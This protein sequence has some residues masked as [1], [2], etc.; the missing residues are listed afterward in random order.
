MPVKTTN[1]SAKFL[2]GRKKAAEK[3]VF[4][5]A[6]LIKARAQQYVPIDTG[7]LKNSSPVSKAEDMG[8]NIVRSTI[9]YLQDYASYLHD[10]KPGGKMDGWQ[11]VLPEVRAMRMSAANYPTSGVS[12]GFNPSARQGWIYIGAEEAKSAVDAAFKDLM[13]LP[14]SAFDFRTYPQGDNT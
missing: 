3:F 2:A 12:G 4:T 11:P 7:A 5:A 13:G 6:T 9:S 8:G 1:N 10:P 14:G